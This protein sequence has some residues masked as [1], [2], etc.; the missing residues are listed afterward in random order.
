M[1]NQWLRLLLNNSDI[2]LE[3]QGGGVIAMEGA[4]SLLI[5]KKA[6]FNNFYMEF[7]TANSN[8]VE[9]NVEYWNGREWINAVD[10]LDGTY[11]ADQSGVVQFSPDKDHSWQR[12]DDSK[13][14]GITTAIIYDMY[15]IRVTFDDV[16]SVGT[17]LSKIAY[18][19]TTDKELL[20]KDSDINEFLASFGE[21]DWTKYI[22]DASVEVARDFKKKNIIKDEGQIL[23]FDDV[24]QPTV[25]KTLFN[26]YL[27]LGE[28]YKERRK[29][30]N[31]LYEKS[32][33]GNYSVDKNNDGVLS[34]REMAV[35]SNRF[36]R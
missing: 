35:N 17:T 19:F 31:D 30:I 14:E 24:S 4:T 15:W 26:I 6:P 12:V 22:L 28:S 9:M 23:R 5:G 16:L 36:H 2:S 27:N 11:G 3:N 18:K 20:L 7:G 8:T 10:I 1:L 34:K 33:V 13:D 29:E 21:T 25:W 32:F